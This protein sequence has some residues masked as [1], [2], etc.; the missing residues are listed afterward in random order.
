MVLAEREEQME[1]M[2]RMLEGYFEKRELKVN[3]EKTKIMRFRKGGGR[4]K[5]MEVKWR[6][7]RIQEVTE[8]KYLGHVFKKTEELESYISDRV[9]K[10]GAVMRQVG[11][12]EKRKFERKWE[13]RMWLFDA[14][15]W[16]VMGYGTEV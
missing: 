8:S 13:R 3:V 16:T 2:I 14:L 12:I 15:I 5:K 9:R 7:R 6:G 4:S 1:S 10:V 11:G